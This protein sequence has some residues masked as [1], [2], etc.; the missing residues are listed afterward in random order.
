MS[1][2]LHAAIIAAILVTFPHIA[3][4]LKTPTDEKVREVGIVL[5]SQ[6]DDAP[7]FENAERTFQPPQPRRLDPPPLAEMDPPQANASTANPMPK[8]DAS[9]I[10]TAG[11]GESAML[12]KFQ[13]P[14]SASS[15][16]TTFWNVEASGSSFLF[17]IDRSASMHNLELAKIQLMQ[18]LHQ[19]EPKSRFQ[20][21]FYNTEPTTLSFEKNSLVEASSTNIAR[22]KKEL[23]SITAQGG[24]EHVKAL[25]AAYAFEPEVIFFLTDADMLSEEE[26]K[27]LTARNRQASIPATI[28]AIEFGGG[29]KPSLE[30]RPLRRLA[31]ANDGSY[32][33]IEAGTAGPSLGS[34]E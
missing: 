24:T 33:Y 7:R 14:P 2:L 23:E 17:V 20:V 10:G 13:P 19:L 15:S 6:Q 29:P 22:V 26:V 3:R 32:S 31:A 21:I 30:D 9:V 5:K 1:L 8:L 4:G 11:R 25:L 12:P 28:Y 27:A 16:R 34:P 18:A